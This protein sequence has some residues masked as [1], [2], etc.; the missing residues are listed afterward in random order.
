VGFSG[1]V[2][3]GEAVAAGC[4][5]AFDLSVRLGLCPAEDA[6]RVRQWFAAAGLPT[7]L[8]DLPELGT[9]DDDF[10]ELMRQDKKA[11][12]GKLVLILARGIG[13][14]FVARDVNEPDIRNFVRD[15]LA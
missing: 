13:Q 1:R 12:G 5:L 8:K 15:A 14:A 9:T 2:L 7:S 3:H 10:V 6:V 11:Q 4:C